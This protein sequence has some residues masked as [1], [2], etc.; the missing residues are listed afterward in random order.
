MGRRK[1]FTLM[2]AIA[3]AGLGLMVA[4]PTLS[5]MRLYAATAQRYAIVTV[6]PGDTLWSIASAHAG[7]STD[8]QEFVDRISDANHLRGGTLQPG[9]HL[10]IPQ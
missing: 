8:I 2:P 6:H 5:S 7:P 1:R 4:L 9:Q 3:L 10:R